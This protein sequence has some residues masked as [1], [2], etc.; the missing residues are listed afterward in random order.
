[1]E[2]VTPVQWPPVE[3][4]DLFQCVKCGYLAEDVVPETCPDCGG[5]VFAE[6]VPDPNYCTEDDND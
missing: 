5:L 3:W 4:N 6:C 2:R 1:M